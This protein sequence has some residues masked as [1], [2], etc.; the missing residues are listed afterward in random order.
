MKHPVTYL[1]L[2]LVLISLKSD[3][4]MYSLTQTKSNTEQRYFKTMMIVG[5][6]SIETRAFLDLLTSQ[7]IARLE[8]KNI[9]ATYYFMVEDTFQINNGILPD[10]F[11]AI[12]VFTPID[13]LHFS[14]IRYRKKIDLLYIPSLPPRYGRYARKVDY[15][16]TFDIQLYFKGLTIDT[17]WAAKLVVEGDYS[18]YPKTHDIVNKII[19]SL[20][21]NKVLL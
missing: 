15:K 7:L 14:Q 16:E 6:G 12:L 2:V 9:E 13:S 1:A 11:E 10:S 18:K 8:D 3:A 5:S 17:I 21:S 4:Q 19:S 20:A